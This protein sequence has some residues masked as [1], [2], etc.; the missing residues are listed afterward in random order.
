MI[1]LSEIGFKCC[2]LEH[3]NHLVRIIVDA[4][5]ISFIYDLVKETEV[6]RPS[7]DPVIKV[8]LTINHSTLFIRLMRKTIEEVIR[9][10]PMLVL[11]LCLYYL[12]KYSLMQ[13][14][15]HGM[16]WTTSGRKILSVQ[17]TLT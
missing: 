1:L 7:I 2:H 8:K 17:A 11:K 13:K 10:W 6:G 12:W 5:D 4:I 9:T 15:S 3:S 14:K 16:L